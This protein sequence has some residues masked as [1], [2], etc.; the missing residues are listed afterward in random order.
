MII[1][2]RL[3]GFLSPAFLFFA[4][5]PLSSSR[6]SALHCAISGSWVSSEESFHLLVGTNCSIPTHSTLPLHF[7]GTRY[8]SFL[9]SL[10]ERHR[11]HSKIWAGNIRHP[12]WFLRYR[13][14]HNFSR[15]LQWWYLS[16][17]SVWV[18]QPSW[19]DASPWCIDRLYEQ[20]LAWRC[21]RVCDCGIGLNTLWRLCRGFGREIQASRVVQMCT[22]RS[23]WYA[24]SSLNHP[25][26]FFLSS[27]RGSD[28][29]RQRYL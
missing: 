4:S 26:H 14:G 8:L 13:I 10:C 25:S 6:F 23:A 5:V 28:W 7:A 16:G 22:T 21:R 17:P 20:S 12:V 3:Q 2:S 24:C 18:S 9:L 27:G 11:C 19:A 29:S 15:T 1:F